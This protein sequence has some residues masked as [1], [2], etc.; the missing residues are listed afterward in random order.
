MSSFSPGGLC[1][2]RAI[3]SGSSR[4]LPVLLL[5]AAACGEKQPAAPAPTAVQPASGP[6]T[7]ETAVKILGRFPP[8]LRANYDD[9]SQVLVADRAFQARLGERALL[10]VSWIAEGEL[11]ARVPAG[12]APGV[13]DLVV[14]DARGRSGAL[15]RAFTVLGPGDGGSEAGAR[16]L[17]REPARGDGVPDARRDAPGVDAG[18]DGAKPD[19][20]APDAPKPDAKKDGPKLD[21]S[22]LDAAKVDL[23][24]DLPKPDLPKP[25]L[26]KPDLRRDLPKPD[27]PKPD[28][29]PCIPPTGWWNASYTNRLPLTITNNASGTLPSGYSVVVSL[30]TQSLVAAGK[31][32]ASGDDLRVVRTVGTTHSELDRRL[33]GMGTA[34]TRIWFKTTAQVATTDGSYFLYY[35]NPAAG[36]PPAA[37]VDGMSSTSKV[38]LAADDFEDDAIG[39]TPSGWVGSANY[40]VE[41]DGSNKVVSLNGSSPNA[42]YLFA[43]D[44]AWTDVIVEAQ[45]KVVLT[46]GDYYG[47]FGRA[48]SASNFDTI[49]F[50]LSTN[51]QLQCYTMR[52]QSP[53]ST[54][55]TSSQLRGTWGL[56][57]AAGTTWHPIATSFVGQQARFFFNGNAIGNYTLATGTMTAGRIGFCAGYA[58]AHAHWDDVVVRRYVYPEPTLGSA[59]AQIRCP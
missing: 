28:L 50:G 47:L 30:D 12:L 25:D 40:K 15:A 35:G 38:Y 59:P 21:Q 29:G 10:A 11:R 16:D 41:L 33:V 58:T 9:P 39:A 17:G 5:L 53:T 8:T 44:F 54:G 27:L 36:A 57:P 18:P 7:A 37:W 46:S 1:S 34:Q 49:W 56:S 52:I 3:A 23:R 22:K 4:A 14:T 26:P 32:L 43:G 2:R 55:L 45:L 48:T 24:K 31:L 51:S 13:Y 20:P 42:N 19:A 6:A